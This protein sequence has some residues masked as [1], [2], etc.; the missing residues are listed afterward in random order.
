[1]ARGIEDNWLDSP[2]TDSGELCE[3][4]PDRERG[5][6]HGIRGRLGG[7]DR[8]AAPNERRRRAQRVEGVPHGDGTTERRDDGEASAANR[9]ERTTGLVHRRPPEH[10]CAPGVSL[11]KVAEQGGVPAQHDAVSVAGFAEDGVERGGAVAVHQ[12]FGPREDDVCDGRKLERGALQQRGQVLG[13]PG[14]NVDG[15]LLEDAPRAGEAGDGVDAA[16]APRRGPPLCPAPVVGADDE[17][18]RAPPPGPPPG[19]RAP[20][21]PPKSPPLP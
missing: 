6:E 11:E 21:P 14:E 2:P 16:V 7:Y 18:R 4:L 3:L 9:R 13:R 20:G 8:A 17:D 10:Q 12:G 19:P 15:A 1:M 5:A